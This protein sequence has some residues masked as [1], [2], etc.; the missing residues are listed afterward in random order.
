[1]YL[2]AFVIPPLKKMKGVEDEVLRPLIS[3]LLHR[4]ILRLFQSQKTF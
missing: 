2:C 3:S 4:D 1:M